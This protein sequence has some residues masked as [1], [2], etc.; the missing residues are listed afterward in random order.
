MKKE[1]FSLIV[2]VHLYLI[3]EDKI[4]NARRQLN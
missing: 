4:L 3:K 2:D 1:R